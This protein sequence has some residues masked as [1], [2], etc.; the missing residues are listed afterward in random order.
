M[1]FAVEMVPGARAVQVRGE[2]DI[3]TEEELTAVLHEAVA[4]GGPVVLD[5]TRLRFIDSSGIRALINAAVAL[6]KAGWCLYLHI[7]DGEV[8]RAIELVGLKAM[9]N[10][11]IVLH[12]DAHTPPVAEAVASTA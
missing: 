5:M 12:R 1:D 6:E 9:P 11:H 10:I 3:A 7:D 4:A 8:R 2:L